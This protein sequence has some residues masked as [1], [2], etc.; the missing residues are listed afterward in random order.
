MNLAGVPKLTI[1]KLRPAR[2]RS[3]LHSVLL[4]DEIVFTHGF[5]NTTLSTAIFIFQYKQQEFTIACCIDIH[6]EIYYQ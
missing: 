1:K 3:T 4:S 6:I 5:I 2:L